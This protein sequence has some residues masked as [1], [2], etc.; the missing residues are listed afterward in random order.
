MSAVY[1]V[2]TERITKIMEQGNIPWVKPWA[3]INTLGQAQNLVSGHKYRGINS[4]LCLGSASPYFV[5]FK[6]IKEMGGSLKKGSKSIPIVFWGKVETESDKDFMFCKY[7]RVFD[8]ADLENV[9]VRYE[10]KI[11]AALNPP[12]LKPNPKF[13]VAESIAKNTGADIRN[14]NSNRA[15]YSPSLD[16]VNVPNIGLHHSSHEYY[17]TM[18]HELG[19]WTGHSSRLNRKELKESAYFGSHNYS[20]EELTAELTAAFCCASLEI[21]T[22]STERNSAAYLQNWLRVLR[23]DSKMLV[24]A[25]QRAQK[26]SDMILK[27]GES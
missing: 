20:Q 13:H 4:I 11:S 14:V 23:N 17:S 7:Y 8:C 27:R 26:A 15:Y 2:V 16:Y 22:E 12:E 18:F 3:G 1:Q 6:Q 10:A 21:S 9:P 5:T 19:H 25:A 24:M